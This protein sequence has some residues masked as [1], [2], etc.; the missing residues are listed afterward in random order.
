MMKFFLKILLVFFSFLFFTSCDEEKREELPKKKEVSLTP[1]NQLVNFLYPTTNSMLTFGDSLSLKY[2]VLGNPLDSVVV[3]LNNKSLYSLPSLPKIFYVDFETVGRHQLIFTFYRGGESQNV[4]REVSVMSDV[5]PKK[6]SY[7]V[8]KRYSHDR[9]AYTQGLEFV[10][11]DFYEST[12]QYGVSDFRKVKLNSGEIIKKVPVSGEYFAEGLTYF[13]DKFYQLTWQKGICL[14]YDKNMSPI[15]SRRLPFETEGWGLTHNDTCLIMSNGSENIYFLDSET[16]LPLK[17]L[18]IYNNTGKVL[19]LNELELVEGFL[20]ANIYQSN[21]I[22]IIDLNTGK[23]IAML[24]MKGLLEDRFVVENQTDVLNGIAY[25]KQN[26][27]LYV[28]GKNWPFLY[29]IEIPFFE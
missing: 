13:K 5:E 25:N 15:A 16:L 6:L 26:K 9:E 4:F 10:G 7:K 24:N 1:V 2:K 18:A 23:C 22:A 17:T 3:K 11:K 8:I 29:Q 12:G 19:S 27:T 21:N 28:T 14:T 20:F